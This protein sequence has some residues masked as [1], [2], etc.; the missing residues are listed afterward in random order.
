MALK[1][2]ATCAVTV[3]APPAAGTLGEWAAPDMTGPKSFV[4]VP[5]GAPGVGPVKYLQPVPVSAM[6]W[7]TNCACIRKSV[8]VAAMFS[9]WIASTLS[10]DCSQVRAALTSKTDHCTA[11]GSRCRCVAVE[12]QASAAGALTL[13]IKCPFKYAANPSS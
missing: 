8:F 7:L 11:C 12:F 1:P 13:A 2:G 9:A 6:L 4:L 3:S 10:P 5:L